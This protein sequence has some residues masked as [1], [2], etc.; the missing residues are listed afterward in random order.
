MCGG[1]AG[2]WCNLQLCVQVGERLA[3]GQKA[4]T[5][6]PYPNIGGARSILERFRAN[7]PHSAVNPSGRT[8]VAVWQRSTDRLVVAGESVYA[9]KP[10]SPPCSRAIRTTMM[11][12]R[13]PSG[14]RQGKG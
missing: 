3:A 14:G 13:S 5:N 7:S 4:N 1:N 12:V 10:R 8:A 2:T 6:N 11:N 9:V